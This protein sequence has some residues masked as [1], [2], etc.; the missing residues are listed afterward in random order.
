MVAVDDVH[1]FGRPAQCDRPLLE[2]VLA[3]GALGIMK[4]L[5]QGR[6]AD[7]QVGVPLEVFR[8]HL[9]MGIVGHDHTRASCL[10][11]NTMFARTATSCPDSAGGNAE[12]VTVAEIG[13]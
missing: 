5:L 12:G 7:I 11:V 6:L 10:D 4:D 8:L 13:L 3:I 1:P 9:L 2:G